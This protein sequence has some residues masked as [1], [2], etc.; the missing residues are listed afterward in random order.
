MIL[1]R[2]AM[3]KMRPLMKNGPLGIILEKSLQPKLWAKYCSF[4]N[5]LEYLCAKVLVL[6]KGA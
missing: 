1:E 4:W 5:Q 2:I 6:L 3:L